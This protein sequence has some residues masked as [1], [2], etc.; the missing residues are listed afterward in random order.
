MNNFKSKEH[1]ERA[2]SGMQ[3]SFSICEY[4]CATNKLFNGHV[5]KV[6]KKSLQPGGIYRPPRKNN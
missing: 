3:H 2:L 4:V 5:R 1:N 6:H